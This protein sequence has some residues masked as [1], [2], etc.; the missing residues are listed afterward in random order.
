VSLSVRFC[1][2]LGDVGVVF[3]F[4]IFAPPVSNIPGRVWGK[5][6]RCRSHNP[7]V[8]NFIL[9]FKDRYMAG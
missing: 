3:S 7:I 1:D 8:L 9:E 4:A 6:R 5:R 2:D